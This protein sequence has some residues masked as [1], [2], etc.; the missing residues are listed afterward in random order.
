[1]DVKQ[2]YLESKGNYNDALARMMNDALIVRMI[3]KFMNDNAVL[4]MVSLYES[5]DY[6]TLFSNAHT[7]KGVAGNLSLTPLFEIAST[8]TEAT[9]NEDGANLDKEIKELQE[10]YKVIQEA[11]NKYLA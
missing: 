8:I 11:Y 1:M 9:R 7:L 5:K 3:S 6:R 10:T 2:F 4:K